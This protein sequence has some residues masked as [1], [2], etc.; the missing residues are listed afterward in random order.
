MPDHTHKAQFII[1]GETGSGKTSFLL[2]LI[3]RLRKDGL[4]VAGF[5]ALSVPEDGPSV[6]YRILDLVSGKILP[7]ASRSYTKGWDSFGPFYFNPEGIRLGIDILEDPLIISH[8]LI[9]VDEVGHFELEGKIWA[10]SLTR[11]LARPSASM[12]LVVRASLVSRV[13][14]QWNLEDAVIMDTGRIKPARAADMILAKKGGT[15]PF[16]KH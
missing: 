14:R 4:S 3:G 7:L 13:I 8:D 6:S 11:I 12:L 9:V 15:R 16:T 10:G 5:A 1:T 2:D